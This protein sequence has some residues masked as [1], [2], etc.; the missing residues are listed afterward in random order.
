MNYKE[1]R[2]IQASYQILHKDIMAIVEEKIKWLNV[3]PLTDVFL[4]V[5]SPEI[6]SAKVGVKPRDVLVIF[7]HKGS[8]QFIFKPAIRMKENGDIVTE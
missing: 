7:R 4:K 5:Y 6:W 8:V 3:R 2:A 1:A